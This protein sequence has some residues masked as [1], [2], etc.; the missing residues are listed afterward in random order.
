MK[1][2]IIKYRNVWFAISGALVVASIIILLNFPLRFGIDFRGG[3]LME[4]EFSGERPT[5]QQ[6]TDLVSELGY[7]E[8]VNQ[9]VGD[10]GM[11]VRTKTLNEDEHQKLLSSMREKFGEAKELRFESVG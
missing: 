6:V 2:P 1:F 10:P 5:P 8:S 11:L 3:S 7:G 9:T 4:V